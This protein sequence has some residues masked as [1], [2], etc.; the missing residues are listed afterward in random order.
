MI[1]RGQKS[2]QVPLNIVGSSTFGRYPKISIEKTYNMFISDQWLVDYAGYKI[3]IPANLFAAASG[4]LA[5]TGR[6]I[7]SSSVLNKLFVVINSSVYMVTLEFNQVHQHVE[8]E[9]IVFIGSLQTSTGVVY[10]TE[11]NGDQILFSDNHSLYLYKATDMPPTF[12]IISVDFVPGFITFHDTYFLAAAQGTPNW[13]RSNSNDGETWDPLAFGSLQ[14]KADNVQAVLRFPSRGNMIYVFGTTVTESWFD[15]GLPGFLPYQRNNQQNIDYGCLNPATIAYMDQYVVWLAVNEKSGPIIVYSDGGTIKQ[16]TS[17][18]IDYLMSNLTAP[19][20]SQGF[21][22]RQDGHLLYHINFYTD[23]LS[24]FYD[25]NTQRFFHAS[26]EN[27]NYFIASEVA[28]FNNQYY[29][30]SKNNGNLYAFDTIFTTYDGQEIPRIRTCKSIRN[31]AQDY[32]VANDIGFTIESGNTDYQF[33]N[34][35]PIYLITQDEKKYITE[36][37]LIYFITEAGDFL[38]TENENNLVSEQIDPEEFAYLIAEQD[39]IVPIT[40]R[41][42]LAISIDGGEHFSSYVPY[43]LPPI[44]QRKNR[45]MWWQAGLANDLTCQFRFWSLGRFVATDGLVTIRG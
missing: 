35:G 41:V 6:G 18:G 1:Y 40:P 5:T 38:I 33:Q 15:V 32:F 44:G 7:Y 9:T 3:G 14:T 37:D 19:E 31:A 28:Y 2:E 30:V 27:M 26:D 45:L 25:F 43:I 17:D 10:I 36:G 39:D 16:I 29:F 12:S 8:S 11:N 21:I 22:F 34:R 24:L 42:D 4:G 20:N 23:N 13:Y